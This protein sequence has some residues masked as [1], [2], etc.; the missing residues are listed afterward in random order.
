MKIF[1]LSLVLVFI[2]SCNNSDDVNK[3]G[4]QTIMPVLVGKGHLNNNTIYNKQ[5]MIITND[6]DWQK[7]LTNFNTIDNNIVAT[8]KETNIDFDNYQI[9]VSIDVKNRSTTVDITN[10][11]ESINNI[12][13]TIQNSQLGLTQDVAFPFH[14]VKIQKSQK[15]IIFK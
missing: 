8:F 15:P 5:N 9:I 10:I 3:F 7:L 14:I 1:I 11:V 2:S 6:N 13:V 4:L 12:T